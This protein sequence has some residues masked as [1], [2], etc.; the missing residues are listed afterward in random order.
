MRITRFGGRTLAVSN[1]V[2]WSPALEHT[3]P[4]GSPPRTPLMLAV[5][6]DGG[7]SFAL[8]AK[9]YSH[10][11]AKEFKQN[12]YLLEDDPADHYCYPAM[13][14]T[15]DGYLIAYYC[16]AGAHRVLNV[17]RIMKVTNDELA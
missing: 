16:D 3:T 12:C 13:I 6:D 17:T 15:K 10:A 14:D 9:D 7:A 1:P 2:T 5:S 8:R 11:A 4:W